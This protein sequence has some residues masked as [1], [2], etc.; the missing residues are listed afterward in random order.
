MHAN[1]NRRASL[2][3]SG[4]PARSGAAGN[5]RCLSSVA[6]IRRFRVEHA[7]RA[8][9]HA[10]ALL[11]SRPVEGIEIS[12]LERVRNDLAVVLRTVA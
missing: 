1:G 12:A 7:L 8:V 4:Q 3:E 2:L 10:L 5:V 6:E 11:D 9:E